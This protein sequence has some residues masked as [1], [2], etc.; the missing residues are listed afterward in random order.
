M[1]AKGF[2]SAG[3]TLGIREDADGK[4]SV[5]YA[6]DALVA[7][8][9]TVDESTGL[10]FLRWESF[11]VTGMRAGYNPLFLEAKRLAAVGLA[12][13][14]TIEP[15]GT[16]NLRKVLGQPPPKEGEETGAPAR[17]SRLP[18]RRPRHRRQRTRASRCPSGSTRSRSREAGSG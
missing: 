16:L 2:V 8:L 9:L 6:G 5:V 11:S 7:S 1:L 14:V 15:D 13:D 3:G 4:A 12:C 17:R 10:D 18:R